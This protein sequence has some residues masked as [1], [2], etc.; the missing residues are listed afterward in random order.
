MKVF[1]FISHVFFF[2]SHVSCTFQTFNIYF[3]I[4]LV[5]LLIHLELF[6]ACLVT[7]LGPHAL[8]R[9]YL[10]HISH[11]PNFHYLFQNQIGTPPNPC[12][13]IL[14]MFSNSLRPAHILQ[15]FFLFLY[16]L[17]ASCRFLSSNQFLKI[18]NYLR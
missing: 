11:V 14:C 12:R 17:H 4:N 8:S 15:L 7:L 1:F 5:H 6:F 2:I 13:S 3:K 9:T 16:I 10:A 18:Q